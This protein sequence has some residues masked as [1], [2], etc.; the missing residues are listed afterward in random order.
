MYDYAVHDVLCRYRDKT[1]PFGGVQLLMIGDL[2]TPA[3]LLRFFQSE[4]ECQLPFAYPAPV[5]RR[6]I[7][8]QRPAAKRPA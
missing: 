6:I 8:P 5:A 1:R 4:R 7:S 2:Q 3:E